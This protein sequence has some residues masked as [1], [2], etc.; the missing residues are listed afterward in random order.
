MGG[1]TQ[2]AISFQSLKSLGLAIVGSVFLANKHNF[3]PVTDKIPTA[4]LSEKPILH[5]KKCF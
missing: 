5:I 3:V 4:G 1:L 2:G